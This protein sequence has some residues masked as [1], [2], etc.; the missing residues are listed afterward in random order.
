MEIILDKNKSRQHYKTDVKFEKYIMTLPKTRV[1]TNKFQWEREKK[2]RKEHA[3][4]TK[5]TQQSDAKLNVAYGETYWT[6]EVARKKQVTS[7]SWKRKIH[8]SQH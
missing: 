1:V 2:Q 8:E 5:K 7:C 4:K 6:K 3:T